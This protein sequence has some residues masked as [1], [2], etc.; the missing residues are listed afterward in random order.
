MRPFSLC[1]IKAKYHY[2]LRRVKGKRGCWK[3]SRRKCYTLLMMEVLGMSIV[4]DD[5]QDDHVSTSVA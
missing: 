1:D 3:D 5:G 4:R 2:K